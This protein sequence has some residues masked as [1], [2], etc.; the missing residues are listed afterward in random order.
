[1]KIIKV[2]LGNSNEAYIEESFSDGINVIYSNDNNKGK[3]IVIQSILYAIGNK[4]IF[5]SS[6]DYKS[7]YY[8]VEFEENGTNFV[9]VRRGD[10]YVISSSIT[11]L[12]VFDDA[13]EFKRFWESHIFSLPKILHDG[14]KRI[15]DMELFSQIF[16]VGQDGKDTSTIFNAGYYH[17]DDFKAMIRSFGGDAE[18][19]LSDGDIRHLK[20]KI[21]EL[22]AEREEQLLLSDFYKNSTPTKEYISRIQ[23]QEAF[24]DKVHDMEEITEQIATIRKNR[25]RLATKKSLWITTL[26]ELR[27]L[28]QTIK[29]GE[30]RCMDCDSTHIAYKGKGKSTYSFDVSTPEMRAQIIKSIED[31]ISSYNEEIERCDYEIASLQEQIGEI[32]K[33]E[34]ITIENLLAYK[35]GISSIQEIEEKVQSIDN[36]IQDLKAK[37]SAGIKLTDD[38]KQAQQAFYNGVIERMNQI[39][40]CI[41]VDSD[42]DYDDIFTRKGSVISG[43]E[44]TVYYIARLISFAELTHHTCPIIMDSFRAEDLSTERENTVLNLLAELKRQCILTTTLKAEENNKYIDMPGINAIDYS[45]NQSNKILNPSYC[46]VFQNLLESL[47]ITMQ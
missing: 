36:S 6:F 20:V 28:N 10:S 1:M 22:E 16:F 2:G 45:R 31:R 7:Y 12:N 4:P 17:K 19:E 40:N 38:S 37:L 46:S 33:D 27:S 39:K 21:K 26:K 44:E 42:Q 3:T 35:N 8:Y 41:D 5:P 11:G 24:H 29:V 30:L 25:N 23:D 13:A 43:S 14:K 15:V 47:G 34:D 18:S 32:M 9:V